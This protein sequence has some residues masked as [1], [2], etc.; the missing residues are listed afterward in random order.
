MMSRLMY[1]PVGFVAGAVAG[2]VA[3]MLFKQVWRIVAGEDDTPNATD[4]ERSWAEILT[5]A[6][7]QGAIFALVKADTRGFSRRACGG[8]TVKPEMPTMRRSSPRRYRVSVVS[9]V[10]QTIRSG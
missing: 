6:A 5:A 10:R 3:G 1:K 4:E 7:L 8:R 2:A 9:S